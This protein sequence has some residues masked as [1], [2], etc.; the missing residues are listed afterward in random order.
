MLRIIGIV[1]FLIVLVLGI[2]FS[3]VNSDP[4]TVNYVLGTTVWP[5]SFVVVCAFSLGVLLSAII[6][7]GLIF[8]LRWRL[9]RLQRMASRQEHELVAL[10]RKSE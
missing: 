10:Q 9:A 7:A 4:V 8:P 2:E 1:L 6:S 5:L 3:A